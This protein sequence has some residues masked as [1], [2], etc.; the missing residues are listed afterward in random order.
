MIIDID[1]SEMLMFPLSFVKQYSD[2]YFGKY[3]KNLFD[4]AY[5][6]SSFMD[7]GKYG[8]IVASTLICK[9]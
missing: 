2:K 8:W 5:S 4:F 7:L 3:K 9:R 1:M 6:T